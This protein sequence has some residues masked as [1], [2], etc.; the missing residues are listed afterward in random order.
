MLSSIHPFAEFGVVLF[1]HGYAGSRLNGQH[2]CSQKEELIYLS[3]NLYFV[4]PLCSS[5]WCKAL[6]LL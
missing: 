3:G 1:K 2:S 6:N 5:A 4:R